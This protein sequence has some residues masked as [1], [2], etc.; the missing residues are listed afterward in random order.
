M[1]NFF[2]FKQ[3]RNQEKIQKV[4]NQ[5]TSKK[6]INMDMQKKKDILLVYP[7]NLILNSLRKY[8]NLIFTSNVQNLTE[9]NQT[10]TQGSP[11]N[12]SN[13]AFNP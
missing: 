6:T 12:C 2:F 7:K 13:Q 3:G 9:R 4:F 1:Q 11:D 10:E 8:F 5:D